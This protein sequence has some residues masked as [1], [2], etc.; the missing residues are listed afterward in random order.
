M[1]CFSYMF[2]CISHHL[3][4]NVM[5]SLLKNSSVEETCYRYVINKMCAFTWLKW[6]DGRTY[7][8]HILC[9][10]KSS[11]Q[12]TACCFYGTLLF[13]K[14][15]YCSAFFRISFDFDLQL[16][17]LLLHIEECLRILHG[18]VSWCVVLRI[19]RAHALPLSYR[20]F[21]DHAGIWTLYTTSSS[22]IE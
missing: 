5:W 12:R 9:K 20:L 11:L 4:W 1:P 15:P 16:S 6:R 7:S 17:V 10:L 14:V 3:E 8:Y 21:A 22:I 19:N 2:R 13:H 18:F